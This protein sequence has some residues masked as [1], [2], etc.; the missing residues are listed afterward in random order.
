MTQIGWMAIALIYL[1]FLML[2]FRNEL[3]GKKKDNKDES[4]PDSAAD[5][6]EEPIPKGDVGQRQTPA[7]EDK[8]EQEKPK[9]EPDSIVDATTFNI[10]AFKAMIRDVVQPIVNECVA[11]AI[12]SKDVEMAD[13]PDEEYVPSKRMDRE[14]ESEAFNDY[15]D[16]E[17]QLEKEDDSVAPPNPLASGVDFEQIAEASVI[18]NSGEEPTKEEH[19]FIFKIYKQIKGT[20]L[21][22]RLPQAQMDK[23]FAC[24]RK[25]EQNLEAY[26]DVPDLMELRRAKQDAVPK[27]K[28]IPSFKDFN[29]EDYV[30]KSSKSKN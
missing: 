26:K 25:V 14:Q 5:P 1:M 13:A 10:D 12:E 28:H 3:S 24:H 11:R 29:M 21:A 27:K 9:Q 17:N 8:T 4:H 18:I 15:R 16:M 2:V 30:R 22:A 7:Q 19:K 23:L 6:P 20:E